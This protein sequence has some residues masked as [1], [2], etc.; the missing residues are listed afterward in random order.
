MCAA[1]A[2]ITAGNATN[3]EKIDLYLLYNLLERKELVHA[4]HSPYQ[5]FQPERN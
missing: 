4:K 3:R 1:E 2:R 5:H